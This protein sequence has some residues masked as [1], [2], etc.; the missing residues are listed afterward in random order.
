MPRSNNHYTT[1]QIALSG[2]CYWCM[3]AV[4]EALIG[5]QAALPGFVTAPDDATP[6]EAVRV[7]FDPRRLPLEALIA[8]HLQTH[9]CTANHARR[10]AYPSAI[11]ADD[12]GWRQASQTVLE[13]QQA[14]FSAPLVTR[15]LPLASFRPADTRYRHYFFAHP[16]RPFCQRRIAPKLKHLLAGFPDWV[17]RE[18][19]AGAGLVDLD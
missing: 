12:T 1:A 9:R 15:A 3:E 11:Y 2:G 7:D 10:D 8:A 6:V 19:L 14:E 5:V 13:R 17:D 16:E 18:R 4:C